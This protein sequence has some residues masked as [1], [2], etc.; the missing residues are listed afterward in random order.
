MSKIVG[1]EDRKVRRSNAGASE[2]VPGKS[3]GKGGKVCDDSEDLARIEREL[4]TRYEADLGSNARGRR[5]R[6][7][8]PCGI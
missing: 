8:R 6:D 1:K 4:R 7:R 2:H 3:V 5:K